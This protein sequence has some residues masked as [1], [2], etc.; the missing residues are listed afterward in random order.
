MKTLKV[1][2]LI[3]ISIIIVPI[4]LLV[5]WV[6]ETMHNRKPSHDRHNPRR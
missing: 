1:F 5:L 4:G 6:T 3:L 2:G